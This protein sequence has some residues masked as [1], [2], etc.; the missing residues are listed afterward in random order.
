MA[1]HAT[2]KASKAGKVQTLERKARRRVKYATQELDLTA[3]MLKAGR[4]A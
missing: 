1:K 3:A 2:Y 4:A